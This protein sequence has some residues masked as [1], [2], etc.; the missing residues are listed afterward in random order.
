[1]PQGD[2][3]AAMQEQVRRLPEDS[4]SALNAAQLQY[5]GLPMFRHQGKLIGAQRQEC[6]FLKGHNDCQRDNNV[7]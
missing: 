2:G 4:G 3:T 6:R 7:A 5:R 1:M